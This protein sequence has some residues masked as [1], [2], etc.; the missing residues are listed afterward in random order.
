M[1][2]TGEPVIQP[3]AATLS[4]DGQHELRPKITALYGVCVPTKR[5]AILAT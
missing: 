1:P 4:C 2:V 5:R 3:G